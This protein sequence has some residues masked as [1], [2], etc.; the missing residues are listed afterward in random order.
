MEKIHLNDFEIKKIIDIFEQLG[1]PSRFHLTRDILND[2][3]YTISIH[4]P[5]NKNDISGLFS[6]VVSEYKNW[7][8]V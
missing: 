6:T 3:E 8:P 1:R 7:T 5:Y 4:I 2:I